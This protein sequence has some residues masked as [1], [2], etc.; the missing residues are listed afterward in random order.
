MDKTTYR[1][2]IAMFAITTSVGLF[3]AYHSH[4]DRKLRRKEFSRKGIT[5]DKES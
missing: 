4:Q 3:N 5:N 2:F 1:I